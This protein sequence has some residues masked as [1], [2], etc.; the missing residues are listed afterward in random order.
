[1]RSYSDSISGLVRRRERVFFAS[2]YTHT[3]THTHTQLKGE[4][5]CCLDGIMQMNQLNTFIQIYLEIIKAILKKWS[6]PFV[7]TK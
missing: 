1:M 7:P 6:G 4:T 3:H 5:C 2:K